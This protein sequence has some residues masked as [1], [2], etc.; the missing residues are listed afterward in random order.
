M[1]R[2]KV[3]MD[4]V[5]LFEVTVAMEF[6]A[7]VGSDRSI[8][9]WESRNQLAHRLA[10]LFFGTRRELADLN[11]AGLAL[12]NGQNTGLAAAQHRIDL[13]VPYPAAVCG[14]QRSF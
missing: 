2:C 14:T 12:N 4:P 5:G 1:R 10:H 11:E 7:I 3:E 6:T 8:L 9:D 13:S